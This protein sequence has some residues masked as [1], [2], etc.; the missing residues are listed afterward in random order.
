M[1]PDWLARIDF[2]T[3]L[4][5]V[6]SPFFKGPGPPLLLH[7]MLAANIRLKGAHLILPKVERMLAAH[8][9][10]PLSPLFDEDLIR[11]GFSLPP[12]LILSRGIEKVIL[13][14]AYRELLPE[15]ILQRPKSG[16]RVPVHF[17]FQGELKRYARHILSRRALIR[18]GIFNADRVKQL[19]TYDIEESRGRYGIRLWMLITFEIWRRLVVEGEA[20]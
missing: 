18:A 20:P 4:E 6:L 8:G 5:A 2:R 15:P 7:R 14:A 11:L 12:R 9:V 13:K 17:W 3:D 19:L 1:N 16:M 10:T